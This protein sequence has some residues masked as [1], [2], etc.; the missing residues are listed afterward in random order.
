MRILITLSLAAALAGCAAPAHRG[1]PLAIDPPAVCTSDRQCDAMWAEALIQAPAISGMRIQTATDS[2]LQTFNPV[3]FDRLGA[4]ARRLPLADGTT[5]IEA[6]FVCKYQCGDLATQAVN[7]FTQKVKA[8]GAA[9]QA[10]PDPGA[11]MTKQAYRDMQI[12]QLEQQNLP[13]EQYQERYRQ[14]MAE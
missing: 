13:Y 7:L 11:P 6:T 8:A 1:P 2:Y 12:K 3:D 5:A 4:T 10:K 9:F 14:I